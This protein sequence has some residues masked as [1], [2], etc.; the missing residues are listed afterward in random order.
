MTDINIIKEGEKPH[1]PKKKGRADVPEAKKALVKKLVDLMDK[2]H[3]I[4]DIHLDTIVSITEFGTE[5]CA[6]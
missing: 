3:I 5:T 6:A 2:N 1:K 4:N